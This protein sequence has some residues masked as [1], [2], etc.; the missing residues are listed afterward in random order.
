MKDADNDILISILGSSIGI[1][2][3]SKKGAI[4]EGV[5]RENNSQSYREISQEIPGALV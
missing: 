4:E 2:S 5:L 3:T 1:A